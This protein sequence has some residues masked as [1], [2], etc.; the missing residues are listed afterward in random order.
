MICM[1]SLYMT[2]DSV[3]QEED[4][5]LDHMSITDDDHYD[6]QIDQTAEMKQ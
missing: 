5:D 1:A 3:H 4:T 2:V 6:S